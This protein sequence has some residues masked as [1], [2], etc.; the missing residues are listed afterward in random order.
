[1]VFSSWFQTPWSIAAICAILILTWIGAYTDD[2]KRIIP[3]WIP[4]GIIIAGIF[5]NGL[6]IWNKL[7]CFAGMT[8]ILLLLLKL[9]GAHSGGGDVNLYCSLCFALGFK[10]AWCVFAGTY[11]LMKVHSI[12]YRSSASGARYPVCCYIAPAYSL[13]LATSIAFF[14]LQMGGGIS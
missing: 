6:T 2:K 12:S 13:L 10:A 14:I 11:L 3:N 5:T 9:T 4:L 8:V 1:M 7:L